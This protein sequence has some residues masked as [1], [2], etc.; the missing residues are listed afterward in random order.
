[1]IHSGST[2]V[3]VW[4][5]ICITTLSHRGGASPPAINREWLYL[6]AA[7]PVPPLLVVLMRV[8]MRVRVQ[9]CWC[10][11]G[12][13]SAGQGQSQARTRAGTALLHISKPL[14]YHYGFSYLG[15]D[16]RSLLQ[17]SFPILLDG[18]RRLGGR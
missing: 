11:C 12:L 15:P 3:I 5:T 10:V 4:C 18:A 16:W 9:I 17:F 13:G 6:V 2:A 7:F 14:T 8:L 1:M